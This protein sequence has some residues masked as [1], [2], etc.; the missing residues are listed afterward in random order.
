MQLNLEPLT[1]RRS[2]NDSTCL[3]QIH[4]DIAEDV[5]ILSPPQF[6]PASCEILSA[7]VGFALTLVSVLVARID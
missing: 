7:S 4:D 6:I 1:T 3:P 5:L 2:A